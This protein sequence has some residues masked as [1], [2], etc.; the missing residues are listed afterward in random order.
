MNLSNSKACIAL[1]L[2]A[3]SVGSVFLLDGGTGEELFA[4]GVPDDRKIWSARAIVDEQYH[5]T[6]KQVHRSFLEAGA[7][8]IT[9]NT[10]GIVPSVGFTEPQI[11]QYCTT[12]GRLAREAVIEHAATSEASDSDIPLV[13]GSLGPLV[14]S[15]RP[16]KVMERRQGSEI[17]AKMISAMAPYVDTLLAETLSS[18]EEAM[19]AVEALASLS[20]NQYLPIM[21][22]FSLNSEGKLR[23]GDSVVEALPRVLEFCQRHQVTLLAFLFNCCEPEAITQALREIQSDDTLRHQLTAHHVLLGAYANRLTPVAPDW[24]MADSTDPQPFRADLDPEHYYSS[25]VSSWIS[26]WNVKIVGGCCAITPKHIAYIEE[27]L[28]SK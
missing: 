27:R 5:D 6:L 7:Q 26:D 1:E 14:E 8:A 20:S 2:I 13:F 16:D 3:S 24:T 15:Y 12:A 19:Q 28:S 4:R 22:S 21:I 18:T 23:S 17:Y 11:V 9:T 25:F 10:Y